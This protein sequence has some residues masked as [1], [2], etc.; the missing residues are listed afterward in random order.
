MKP[1]LKER[2]LLLWEPAPK[3]SDAERRVA[4]RRLQRIL[5]RKGTD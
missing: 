4:L 5:K 3:M 2:Q 1:S